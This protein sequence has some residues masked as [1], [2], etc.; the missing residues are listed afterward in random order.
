MEVSI[1]P[2]FFYTSYET[3]FHVIDIPGAPPRIV[4]QPQSQKVDI[5]EPLSLSCRAVGQG[6]LS[7]L[8][9][10][11]GLSI[12]METRPEYYINCFTDEDEGVYLCRISNPWGSTDSKMAEVCMKEDD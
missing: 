7:Y 10:F 2:F 11:N 12:A 1:C 6:D 5:G 9:F 8:W 4:E 3:L